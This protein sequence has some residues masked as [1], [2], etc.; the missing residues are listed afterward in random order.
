MSL[1]SDL[2]TY[3]NLSCRVGS[4]H[5]HHNGRFFRPLE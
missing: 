2:D 5:T 4:S 1:I 3:M